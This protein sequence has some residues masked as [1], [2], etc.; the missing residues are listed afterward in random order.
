M[1]GGVI[2]DSPEN[3]FYD[4]ST[5]E[6]TPEIE[7]NEV[8]IYTV[9]V[10][11]QDGCSKLRTITVNPSNIATIESVEVVD[12]AEFGSAT[13]IVSGEGDYEFAIDDI[14]GPYQDSN[15]FDNLSPGFHTIYVR[16]KNE[17]GIVEKQISIIGFPKF[18]TPNGDSYNDTWQVYGVNSQF[19]PN[20]IIYIFDRYGKLLKQLSASSPGWDGTFNGER[21][22]DNDYWFEVTLEDGRVYRNHFALKR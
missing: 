6:S 15:F 3:Y 22:P 9:I 10:T 8:G 18:F 21:M 17:C 7:I 2:N 5:G 12:G 16:D 1:T 19:Q 13:I 14:N 20:T 11:N 4:W